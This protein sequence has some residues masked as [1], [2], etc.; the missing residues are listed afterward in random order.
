M[1]TY[2][3]IKA[4]MLRKG[5]ANYVIHGGAPHKARH[6][7]VEAIKPPGVKDTPAFAHTGGFEEHISGIPGVGQVYP[8]EYLPDGGS[9]GEEVYVDEAGGHHMH[10]IDGLIR[11]VGQSMLQQG[12]NVPGKVV[13][14]RA[15]DLYNSRRKDKIPGSDAIDWR[16][17]NLGRLGDQDTDAMST[18]NEHGLVTTLTNSHDDKHMYGTFLESYSIPFNNE[19]GQIMAEAGHPNPQQHSWVRKPYIKPHRLHLKPDGQ[20]GMEFGAN[21]VPSGQMLPGGALDPMSIRNLKGRLNDARAFQNIS[22]WGVGRHI[23]NLYHLPH[24]DAAPDYTGRKHA[25]KA[26]VDSFTMQMLMTL[27]YD[28]EA[29]AN[30]LVV[31]SEGAKRMV[32][33]LKG[34]VNG[35]SLKSYFTSEQGIRE[36][37]EQLSRY[38]SLNHVYGESRMPSFDEDKKKT[39]RANTSGNLTHFF[40]QRYGDDSEEGR[41]LDLFMGHSKRIENFKSFQRNKDQAHHRR[42]KDSF[43]NALLAR[44]LGI[45][46]VEDMPTPEEVRE[47]GLA[48]HDTPETRADAPRVANIMNQLFALHATAYGHEL[49]ELPSAEE[50]KEISPLIDHVIQGGTHEDLS[51]LG[52]PDHIPYSDRMEPITPVG[53]STSDTGMSGTPKGVSG[54]PLHP[55]VTGETPPPTPPPQMPPPQTPPPQMPPPTPPPQMPPPQPEA[56][57][58]AVRPSPTVVDPMTP[59]LSRQQ[60]ARARFRQ[61]PLEQVREYYPQR[62]SLA[63]VPQDQQEARL[64]QFRQLMGDPYQT[65]LVDFAKSDNVARVLELLQLEEARLDGAIMKQVPNS[66][67][68]ADSVYDINHIAKMMGLTSLDVRTILHSKGDWHRISKTYGYDDSVVKV[69]KVAFGGML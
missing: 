44:D 63:N 61:A 39:R 41:G 23:S 26:L 62:E 64:Q 22:S 30:N 14:D 24:A 35:R 52:V 17:I 6:P 56:R 46:H 59:G 36:L 37:G 40:G 31:D 57:R 65:R 51:Q 15:I 29:I 21:S 47:A 1:N 32:S 68:N 54:A 20:G 55:S 5:D 25:R 69:V 45:S 7:P 38:P 58:V 48:L 34:E 2:S 11:A 19:L 49:K 42:A 16:K 12:I 10:G 8:G 27:G 60:Q 28:R 66:A 9:H 33:K 18:R 50:M 4:V 3:I 53:E 43:S 67:F 13:V